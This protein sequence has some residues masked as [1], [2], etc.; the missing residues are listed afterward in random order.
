MDYRYLLLDD[1]WQIKSYEIKQRDDYECQ[2]CGS[3][4]QLNVHH[5]TYI[6]DKLP[7]DYPYNYL[8]TLCKNCHVIEHKILR[9]LKKFNIYPVKALIMGLLAIDIYNKIQ[10]GEELKELVIIKDNEGLTSD[11]VPF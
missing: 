1:R 9:A 5:V 3:F 8:I 4:E 2:I 11:D 10:N 6:K 7:W